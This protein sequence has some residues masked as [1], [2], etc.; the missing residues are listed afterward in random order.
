[1][2]TIDPKDRTYRAE[3]TQTIADE[4]SSNTYFH[5]MKISS[6]DPIV[7]Q[8]TQTYAKYGWQSNNGTI[9]YSAGNS[10]WSGNPTTA[11]TK[12]YTSSCYRNEYM[13]PLRDEGS[14]KSYGFFWNTDWKFPTQKTNIDQWVYIAGRYN[15]A[16][17]IDAFQTV[18]G[19]DRQLIS[20]KLSYR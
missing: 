3:K 15:G 1:M 10:C 7:V 17:T 4:K 12:W 8:L 5:E 11:G 6:F 19:E 14:V 2:V 20:F 18:T 13:S 9:I 16:W